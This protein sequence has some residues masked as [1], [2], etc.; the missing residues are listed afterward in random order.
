M[1]T[2]P[3]ATTRYDFIDSDK[4]IMDQR[5]RKHQ[6]SQA[7]Y[8]RLLKSSPDEKEASEELVVFKESESD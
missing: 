4:R 5:V 3:N 7:E 2:T 1:A 6:L 8:Q